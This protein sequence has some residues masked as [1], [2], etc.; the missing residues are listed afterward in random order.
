MH[1]G[2]NTM[3]ARHTAKPTMLARMGRWLALSSSACLGFSLTGCT[4]LTQ[5]IDGVPSTRL[6]QQFFESEKSNLIPIDISLLAKEQERE[7]TLGPGDILGISV[8][9]ILPF[10]EPDQIPPLPPVN[11]PEADSTLPPSTGFPITVLDDGTITL[12]LLSCTRSGPSCVPGEPEPSTSA[13][14]VSG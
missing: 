8:D 3:V 12:P 1:S 6:P 9:R 10:A 14:P 4:A 5:P 2:K 13:A 11:F 7:Y